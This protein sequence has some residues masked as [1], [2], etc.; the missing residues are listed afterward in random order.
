MTV[1]L[2]TE[3]E[4][5]VWIATFAARLFHRVDDLTSPRQTEQEVASWQNN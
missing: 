4:R 1:A 5:R 3:A 2:P